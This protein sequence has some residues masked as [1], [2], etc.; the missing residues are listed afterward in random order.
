MAAQ[1][2]EWIDRLRAAVARSSIRQ[3]AKQLHVSASS[4]SMAL[5]G[6]YP[7]NALRLKSRV[8]AE[9]AAVK[10]RA[11]LQSEYPT[12][13]HQLSVLVDRVGVEP[14]ARKYGCTAAT[15]RRHLQGRLPVSHRLAVRVARVGFA[16]MDVCTECGQ[17]KPE[18]RR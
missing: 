17:P 10:T 2:K 12:L 11:T 14:V 13:W 3:V 7:G 18:A 6:K 9:L 8:L 16:P 1:S 15:L 5:A 4:V